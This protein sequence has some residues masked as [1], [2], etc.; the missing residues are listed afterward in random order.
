MDGEVSSPLKKDASTGGDGGQESSKEKLGS[1]SKKAIEG[2]L[3]ADQGSKSKRK[4][5]RKPRPVKAPEDEDVRA[6]PTATR[7]FP[8]TS[9][10]G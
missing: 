5:A 10:R 8:P 2:G 9:V 7:I 1:P 6:S 4:Y 3:A